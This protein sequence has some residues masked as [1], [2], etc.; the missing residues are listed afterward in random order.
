MAPLTAGASLA[1]SI[2]LDQE[3]SEDGTEVREWTLSSSS[4]L[5]LARPCRVSI[6]ARSASIITFI[7]RLP[8]PHHHH[9]LASP[10][11]LPS[12]NWL[13]LKRPLVSCYFA[14]EL[15]ATLDPTPPPLT[16]RVARL[17]SRRS[18]SLRPSHHPFTTTLRHRHHPLPTSSKIISASQWGGVDDRGTRDHKGPQIMGSLIAAS[19]STHPTSTLR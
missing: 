4:R 1:S 19:A 11:S 3:R 10:S 14:A 17:N 6:L 7:A 18:S 5:A 16:P 12:C 13:S 15:V 8:L 9:R 2:S